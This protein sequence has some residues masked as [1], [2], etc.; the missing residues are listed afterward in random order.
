MLQKVHCLAQSQL[1]QKNPTRTLPL[2]LLPN[3]NLQHT[4]DKHD[5]AEKN[6][7]NSQATR[8]KRMC[9]LSHIFGAAFGP[10]FS[11][12]KAMASISLLDIQKNGTSLTFP[13]FHTTARIC[14]RLSCSIIICRKLIILIHLNL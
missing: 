1:L 14:S 12:A 10:H 13:G 11:E 8:S 5:D 2:T 7:T 6:C 9:Y 3:L 4:H